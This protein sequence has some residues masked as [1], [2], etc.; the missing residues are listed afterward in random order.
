VLRPIFYY[1]I[2][3]VYFIASGVVSSNPIAV[4]GTAALFHV[5]LFIGAPCQI[6]LE[7]EKLHGKIAPLLRVGLILLAL[8]YLVVMIY[9]IF[10]DNP[11]ANDP[12]VLVI[13][14]VMIFMTVHFYVL[15]K[16][17]RSMLLAEGVT[18]DNYRLIGTFFMFIY[19]P[20]F[21][22]LIYKRFMAARAEA[23][24]ALSG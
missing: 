10:D 17:T 13:P 4:I 5:G 15:W 1:L 16:A 20:L 21:Y 24:D 8:V 23:N 7:T 3:L 12:A 19:L 22:W 11:A 9:S 18:G 6:I 14:A 2:V